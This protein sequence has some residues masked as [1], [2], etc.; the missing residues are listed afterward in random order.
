MTLI[1]LKYIIALAKTKHF[2]RAAEACHV[3]QPTLSVAIKKLE[4]TLGVVIFER[5]HN[6][7]RITDI[8]KK[9]IDQAQHAL[10]EVSKIQEIADS[11]QSHIDSP[12]KIGAIYTVA[13]YLFPALIPVIKKRA[14]KMP[15]II[16]E[17]FTENLR[18]KLQSGELDAI[19][20]ALPFNEAGVVKKTLYDEPFV[21]LMRKN[22]PLAL[23][24][25][26]SKTDLANENV[27]LLGNKNCFRE[28]VIKSC[29]PCYDKNGNHQTMENASL[30]T[31]RHMVAS[32]AGITILPSSATAIKFYN[33]ILCT[34]PFKT[35]T[36][37][38]TIALAWRAHFP[39][40]KAIDVIIESV[41]DC[42]LNGVC[43]SR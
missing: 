33:S 5:H 27:L 34:K 26:I 12:L 38:R 39:R 30:E 20:I 4:S 42:H 21:V 17:D 29:P 6:D 2:G 8:G 19:F 18:L 7:I 9:I 32:G 28:Q 10:L 37:Q 41:S 23:K 22:H 3:S 11:N 31:V 35:N 36:P 15:L 43:I 40:T 25:N 14:P 1:E 13:P 16:Q 24:K